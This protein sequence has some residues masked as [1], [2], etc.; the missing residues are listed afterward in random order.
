MQTR[1][2]GKIQP[3][4]KDQINGRPVLSQSIFSRSI[5][6]Q[7]EGQNTRKLDK[8]IRRSWKT[9]NKARKLRKI[10]AWCTQGIYE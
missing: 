9:K 3:G 5:C 2:V 1:S 8:Q 10:F 7:T 6:K 4:R